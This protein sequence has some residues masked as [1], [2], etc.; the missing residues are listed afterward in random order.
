MHYIPGIENFQDFVNFE[1]DSNC[2]WVVYP[3]GAAGDL[4]AS[5]VN[6]HYARTGSQFFGITDTGQVIFRD[7]NKKE[8]NSN[9]K[10]DQNFI[11]T[12]N[13]K[14]SEENLN[15]SLLDHVIFSNHGWQE[16][17]V[18]QIVKF[19]PNAKIIRILPQTNLEYS[20]VKWLAEYKNKNN[21]LEFSINENF[22]QCTKIIHRRVLDL[23]FGEIF[24][25][26]SFE[27]FYTKLINFLDLE[28][29]LIRFDFV[30]FW[31][32]KQHPT[33]QS[34]LKQLSS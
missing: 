14:L 31:L 17:T 28:Y 5:I 13:Q 12:T 1:Q 6:Y 19:F 30:K 32:S 8:F 22:D 33:I 10:I 16:E 27:Q 34:K 15:L 7:S 23:G 20:I 18:N 21:E 24:N 11:N 26:D 25:E 3:P 2:T 9:F 29:K 4:V